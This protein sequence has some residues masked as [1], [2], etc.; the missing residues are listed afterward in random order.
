MTTTIESSDL[1][2]SWTLFEDIRSELAA[3][4]L[5]HPFVARCGEGRA[6]FDE[7][8]NFLVQHGRYASYFTRY[9]CALMS[10]L[11][12]GG[13]VLHLAENLVEELGYG[14][15]NRVPHSRIYGQMLEGFGV[16]L[17]T[18]AIF[19]ETQNL[20]DTMFMLC[21][22][23]RGLAGLGAL[24]LGAEAIVPVTYVTIMEGLRSHD[25]PEQRLEFFAMH[26]QCDDEHAKTMYSIIE[27]MIEDSPA[28]AMRIVSAGEMAVSAR[29]R[30]FDGLSRAV[31]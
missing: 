16:S 25:V 31:R 6:S 5:R 14:S 8:R 2:R 17:D 21:R 1:A 28:D 15:D 19:P 27:R 9:L 10:Q 7:L 20:I 11:E 26:V 22:Q 24:Y 13:D 29:L 18:Q 4:V 23:P 30:F 12:D 3:R